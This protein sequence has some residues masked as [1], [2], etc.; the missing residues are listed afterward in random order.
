MPA[1]VSFVSCQLHR[2]DNAIH[3]HGGAQ[4]GP[5]TQK[6]HFATL[7]APQGL[8]GGVIDDFDGRPNAA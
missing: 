4:A 5:Q 7:V 2:L 6:E 3:D 1:I 8:H